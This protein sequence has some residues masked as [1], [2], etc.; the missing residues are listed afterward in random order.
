[1]TAWSSANNMVF[2]FVSIDI[3]IH[4][5]YFSFQ[6]LMIS[7]YIYINVGDIGQPCL[8]P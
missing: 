2:N 7:F 4:V 6:S 5:V 8:T 3:F 1:M